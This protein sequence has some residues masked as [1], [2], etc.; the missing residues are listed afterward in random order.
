MVMIAMIFLTALDF[1]HAK[2]A[3]EQSTTA[4]GGA[5]TKGFCCAKLA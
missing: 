2:L 5:G 1:F 3:E 4:V